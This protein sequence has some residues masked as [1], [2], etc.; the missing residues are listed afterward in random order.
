MNIV[1]L[2]VALLAPFGASA[3]ALSCSTRPKAGMADVNL[4]AL[5][6]VTKAAAE[7][8]ALKA[9]N[10]AEATV[11]SSELEAAGGCLNYAFDITVPGKTSIVEVDAGTSKLLSKTIVGSKAQASEVAT[12]HVAANK[13]K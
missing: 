7:S 4:P 3:A 9:V 5:A 13:K 2:V 6:K 12:D 11:S 1:L 8:T 10:V